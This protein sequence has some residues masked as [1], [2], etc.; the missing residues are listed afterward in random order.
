[1]KIAFQLSFLTFLFL[2]SAFA[3]I[4]A[5]VNVKLSPAGSFKAVTKD[6]KGKAIKQGGAVSAQNIVVELANLNSGISLRDEHTK[7]KYLEVSKYP[8]AILV[9]A[10]GENGKGTG[11]IKIK[12]IEKPIS[13]TYKINGSELTA[14]FDL[15]LSD[16]GIKGIKY[17]GVGV[18]D[19]IKI[20]ITVPVE[21][22]SAKRK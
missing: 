13:G 19:L 10:K 7:N 3:E 20:D 9:S 16:F 2:N 22:G 6:I 1:M 17:M 8:S 18:S 12:G 5:N 11:I 15:K 14:E 4:S 21:E